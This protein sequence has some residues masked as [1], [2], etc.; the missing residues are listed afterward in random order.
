M[1]DWTI[2][3]DRFTRF[4]DASDLAGLLREGMPPGV[5]M[6]DDLQTRRLGNGLKDAARTMEDISLALRLT[7]PLETMTAGQ[8]LVDTLQETTPLVMQKAPPF[9]LLAEQISQAYKPLVLSEPLKK[10]DWQKNIQIQ[11]GLI[12]WYLQKDQVVQA[13][14]LA[15]EWVVSA[16]VYYFNGDSLIDYE[17][18][19]RPV[20]NT[21]NNEVERHKPNPRAPLLPA[22]DDQLQQ[23]AN[24]REIGKL[25][26][27]LTNLRNDIAHVGMNINPKDAKK[28]HR[29]ANSIYPKLIT[30]AQILGIEEPTQNDPNQ[31]IPPPHR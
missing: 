4:G 10:S 15:R 5:Q 13:L 14:T 18:C 25:W 29:D 24:H 22:V 17:N 2:A 30:L 9:G 19:R 11:L 12:A 3:T 20:E 16:L 1:L 31:P 26:D 7:R 28:I 23:L 6:R 21:L 27:T 8:L